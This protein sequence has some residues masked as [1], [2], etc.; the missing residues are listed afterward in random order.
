MMQSESGFVMVPVPAERVLEIYELLGRPEGSGVG[1]QGANTPSRLQRGRVRDQGL[2]GPDV[3]RDLVIRMYTE[4]L[5]QQHRRLI[6]YLADNAGEWI[7]T[8]DIAEALALK[9]GTRSLAGMLGAFGRRASHRYDSRWP[10]AAKRNLEDRGWM[11]RM[12][13]DVAAVIKEIEQPKH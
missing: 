10:F 3:D 12:D 8:K 5:N 2:S 4:S 9:K 11:L 7:R 13:T 6:E 1:G